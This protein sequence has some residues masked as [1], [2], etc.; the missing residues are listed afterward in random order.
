M[1]Y[2][3]LVYII[4]MAFVLGLYLWVYDSKKQGQKKE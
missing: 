1:N 4:T 3:L 2:L